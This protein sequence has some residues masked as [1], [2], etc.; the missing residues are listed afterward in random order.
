MWVFF[1]SFLSWGLCEHSDHASFL[2]IS[3]MIPPRNGYV[4]DFAVDLL[5]TD[6]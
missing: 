5:A 6:F 1:P 3:S 4:H 2:A